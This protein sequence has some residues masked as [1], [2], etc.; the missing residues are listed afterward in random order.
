MPEVLGVGYETI[1]RTFQGH[2]ALAFLAGL[3]F[4]KLM[5]SCLTLGSGGS[6]GIFAPSLVLGSVLGAGFGQVA[7]GVLP[8]STARPGV[9]AVVGMA[10]L[11]A[12]TTH[13]P[14]SAILIL[15]EMTQDFQIIL[16]LMI[17]CVL[18]TT[19]A[20]G[21]HR[22]SIYTLKLVRRGVRLRGGRDAAVLESITVGETMRDDPTVL[23]EAATFNEVRKKVLD[24][25]YD[26][27]PVVDRRDKRFC[28]IVTLDSLR[29]FLFE[30]GLVDVAVARDLAVDWDEVLAPDQTL[31]DAR[32]AFARCLIT[33]LPVVDPQTK[34]IRGILREHDL[35]A[36]YNQAVERM[37]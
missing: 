24:S 36:A 2:F 29:S 14:I 10:A 26:I 35:H 31:D 37:E 8:D 7:H 20:R 18:S 21:I 4:V 32:R 27:F 19:V 33:E 23:E 17:A 28:G 34:Q 15:F 5:A 1:S 30:E 12:G 22:E 9:Y 16:P 3:F 6:G 13:A 11:V 25:Q